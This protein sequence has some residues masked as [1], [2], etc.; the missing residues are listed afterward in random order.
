MAFDYSR[1]RATAERQIKNFGQPATLR[2]LTP[3]AGPNPGAP[4]I[5]DYACRIVP[6]NYSQY[7]IDGTLVKAGDRKVLI[8]TEGLPVAPQPN[9]RLLIGLH[10]YSLLTADPLSPGGVDVLY[11][12][13][14]RR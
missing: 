13:Q 5:T 6:L 9:D 2:R 12:A 8:S 10:T 14:A 7:H 4:T 3:G 11:I 1:A